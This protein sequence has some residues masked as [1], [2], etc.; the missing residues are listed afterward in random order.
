MTTGQI[1]TDHSATDEDRFDPDLLQIADELPPPGE[2]RWVTRR[3][4]AVVAA[5]LTGRMTVD[6]VCARYGLSPDE[7]ASWQALF[8][9]HGQAGLR[10]TRLK[11]YRDP[12]QTPK[13]SKIRPRRLT[14][15][16]KV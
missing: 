15:S 12:E 8:A 6:A 14:L 11:Q 9:A 3:K 10:A 13:R 4:A 2:T 5:V 16:Q 7:F 1:S